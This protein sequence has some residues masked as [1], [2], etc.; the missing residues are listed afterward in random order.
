[1]CSSAL[2]G[3]DS[4]QNIPKQVNFLRQPTIARFIA[5][6]LAFVVF[7]LSID[8]PD[9]LVNLDDDIAYEEDL[10]VNEMESL[11]EV[12]LEKALSMEDAVPETD[13]QDGEFEFKKTESFVSLPLITFGL[14]DYTPLKNIFLSPSSG[15]PSWQQPI[16]EI[17]PPPPQV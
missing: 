12:I 13:D 17:V 8:P 15:A 9:L 2:F 4:N 16:F 1:M 3:L 10:S 11:T 6:M 7:N 5:G 14:V